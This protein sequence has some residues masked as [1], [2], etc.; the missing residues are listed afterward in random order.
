MCYTLYEHIHKKKGEIMPK[1]IENLKNTIL[2]IASSELKE[3]GYSKLTIRSIAEKANIGVGTIYNYFP[4]KMILVANIIANDWKEYLDVYNN[5]SR[6]SNTL[7]EGFNYIYLLIKEFYFKYETI[8]NEISLDN[9][10]KEEYSIRHKFFTNQISDKLK[11]V[12][13]SYS[14]NIEQNYL[15]LCSD[16]LISGCI[17]DDVKKEILI[18]AI[19]K[20]L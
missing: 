12:F 7:E 17:H 5:N 1:I 16:L 14:V 2:D 13:D 8:F 9:I 6:N 18:K 10:G 20:I 15:I 4:N 19:M 11:E 3:I